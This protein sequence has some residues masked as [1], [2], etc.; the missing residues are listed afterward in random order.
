MMSMWSQSAPKESMRWASEAKLEKSEDNIDGAILAATI[1]DL[2]CLLISLFVRVK[3]R[4]LSDAP[5]ISCE[6]P[7]FLSF[8]IYLFF[9]EEKVYAMSL[10][11][12]NK[13]IYFVNY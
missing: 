13:I 4:L 7:V 8:F 12:Q 1:F 2:L 11:S 10:W 6:R 3:L 5:F 9:C